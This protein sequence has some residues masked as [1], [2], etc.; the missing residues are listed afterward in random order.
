M[1]CSRGPGTRH[2]P[3]GPEPI[4]FRHTALAGEP[5]VGTVVERQELVDLLLEQLRC[6]DSIQPGCHGQRD[7]PGLQTQRQNYSVSPRCM[8]TGCI[9]RLL[10]KGRHS[11]CGE[12]V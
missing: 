3:E 6:A 7:H 10:V 2:T 12:E 5:R 1:I 8:Q 9:H 11:R 4:G